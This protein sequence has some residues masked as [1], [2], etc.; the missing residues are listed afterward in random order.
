M[1]TGNAVN[2]EILRPMMLEDKQWYNGGSASR[3]RYARF[4]RFFGRWRSHSASVVRVT[5]VVDLD[6]VGRESI[7]VHR[8][9]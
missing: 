6:R 9:I 8:A 3:L 2:C 7:M 4:S 1:V 5:R